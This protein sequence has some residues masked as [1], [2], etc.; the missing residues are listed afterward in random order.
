MKK[1]SANRTVASLCFA[2]AIVAVSVTPKPARGDLTPGTQDMNFDR[3]TP[4]YTIPGNA[5]VYG[6]YGWNANYT[7]GFDGG[8]FEKDIQINFKFDANIP[9]LGT[10]AQQ[11]A[12]VNTAITGLEAIWD[13]KYEIH[14]N[15]TGQNYPIIVNVTTQGPFN[16][17]V[18]V[19]AGPGR[20]DMTHW[21]SDNTA[22]VDAHEV[23][24][25]MGLYDE[26]KGGAIDPVGITAGNNNGNPENPDDPPQ[27][28]PPANPGTLNANAILSNDGLMGLGAERQPG[29]VSSLLSAI[30]R[31]C[32]P[33][34]WRQHVCLGLG[35]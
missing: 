27:N 7:R 2:A 14:D 11:T 10:Q 5:T 17:I 24:H 6:P 35:S 32:D 9:N 19:S 34:W 20:S 1:I 16:Q 26:Y 12:W 18:Q 22:S 33:N 15:Q 28:P 29:Y 8:L 30:S 3:S 23:G 13:N 25:M 31:L 21:Y 4:A